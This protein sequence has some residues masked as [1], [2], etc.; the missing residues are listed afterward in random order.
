MTIN[1]SVLDAKESRVTKSGVIACS[2]NTVTR[3]FT[4]ILSVPMIGGLIK[5]LAVLFVIRTIVL[6]L[7]V[8]SL[9]FGFYLPDAESN[10]VTTGFFWG[11]FWPFFMLVSLA[12]FGPLVCTF[13][14]HGFLG[15]YLTRFGLRKTLPKRWR[16]PYLGLG[17]LLSAYWGAYY[18]FAPFDSPWI[19]ALFFLL[20]TMIAISAFFIFDGMA[21]CKYICP[22]AS[23]KNAFSRVG[24]AWLSTSSSSCTGCKTFECAKACDYHLSPFTFDQTGSMRHCSLCMDCARACPS[25]RWRIVKPAYALLQ[26]IRGVGN[27]DIW[28]YILLLAVISVTMRFH[29]A[30]G[31]T[32]IAEQFPWARTSQWLLAYFP[33]LSGYGVDVTGLVALLYALIL[34]VSVCVVGLAIGGKILGI[35]YEKA[36]STLGYAFAPLMII[37]GLS[38][39]GEFFFL[40]YY[41]DIANAVNQLLNLSTNVVEPLARRGEPWLHRFVVFQYIAVLWSIY[42]FYYRLQFI[43][44][45]AWRKWLAFPFITAMPVV[46]LG[47]LLYTGYV[48]ATYGAAVRHVH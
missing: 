8:T 26:K 15:I 5:S 30:L 42:L 20:L 40:H 3:S 43:D 14:P 10:Y 1:Q 35:N 44:V 2:G 32:A 48:F 11:L 9:F 19:T 36:F 22:M 47:L 23:V 17:V 45:N 38:H 7:F 12:T 27:I 24:F 16:N 39:V 21:Y 31:R 6:C 13:C 28:T 34:T 33:S 46:Y 4:D 41:S 29:H 25:V 37:G 18:A